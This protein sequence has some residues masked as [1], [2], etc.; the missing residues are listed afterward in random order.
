MTT[1]F[2]FC[3]IFRIMM[4]TFNIQLFHYTASCLLLEALGIKI[5]KLYAHQQV[6]NLFLQRERSLLCKI[7]WKIS[8]SGAQN[9]KWRIIAHISIYSMI[10]QIRVTFF[11]IEWHL[12]IV[13]YSNNAL[14]V[15]GD[16]FLSLNF[17]RRPTN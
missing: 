13:K 4:L 7:W 9:S 6:Y 17:D 11:R 5:D 15:S 1:S 14:P 12:K 8:T 16:Y 3:S 10:I 2:S